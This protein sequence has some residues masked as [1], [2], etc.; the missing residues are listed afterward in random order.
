[1]YAVYF[2]CGCNPPLDSQIMK[3][4]ETNIYL[5]HYIK[6]LISSSQIGS[7]SDHQF[8][9]VALGPQIIINL[10][11]A[12]YVTHLS[13]SLGVST[14]PSSTGITAWQIGHDSFSLSHLFKQWIWTMCP[15]RGNKKHLYLISLSRDIPY[16]STSFDKWMSNN[17]YFMC[18]DWCLAR[19][20]ST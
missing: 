6:S 1:M 8:P 15:H 7:Q 18:G 16:F 3:I 5:L 11:D 9:F 14:P 10:L 20:P 19:N 4:S 12:S 13:R 17:I 2:I